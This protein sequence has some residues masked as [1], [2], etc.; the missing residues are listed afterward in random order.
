MD[1]TTATTITITKPNG[2][3]ATLTRADDGKWD[4]SLNGQA[5]GSLHYTQEQ[6]ER[7]VPQMSETCKIT[8]N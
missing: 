7:M 1:L 2:D 6:V 8:I 3:T 5:G 4:V